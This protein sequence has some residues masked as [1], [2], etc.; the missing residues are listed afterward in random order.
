MF[1]IESFATFLNGAARRGE[2]IT[3]NGVPFGVLDGRVLSDPIT[4]RQTMMFDGV[5]GYALVRA[6]PPYEMVKALTPAPPMFLTSTEGQ[7]ATSEA[8][9]HGDVTATLT[10]EGDSVSAQDDAPDD[11]LDELTKAELAERLEAAGREVGSRA[12]KADMIALL[13]GVV[14]TDD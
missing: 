10:D 9:P 2:P 11:G 8:D 5:D 4:E 7:P 13:R 14:P 12:T 6:E 3:V 1:R